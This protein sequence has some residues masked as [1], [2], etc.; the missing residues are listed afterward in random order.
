M[1]PMA[2]KKEDKVAATEAVEIVEETQNEL[3]V[4]DDT[5]VAVAGS[6]I[7]DD[8][9]FE[10]LGFDADEL[11][12]L[13][14]LES[15]NASDIRVPF[16]KFWAVTKDGFEAGDIQLPDGSVIK[17]SQ[18]EILKGLSILKPATV[19]VYF[20]SPYKP[21]NTFICRSLDGKTGATD[22]KFA[23]TACSSCEFSQYPEEGAPPCREQILLLCTLA[24]GTL[25]HLL[26]S[27]MS[28]GNWKR[29]FLSVEM[30]KNMS[31]VKKAMRGK[32]VLAALN[33]EAS[34][35][36]TK[37]DYGVKPILE[38]KVNKEKPLHDFNRI[39]ENLEAYSNYKTFETE[40][41]ESAAKFAQ[42]EQTEYTDQD[43]ATNGENAG[44][45]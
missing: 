5:Q 23:G 27:G 44:M 22:G 25:F 45:F 10:S 20:P 38:F 6:D 14:G 9:D 12:G 21:S 28:V 35:G 33:I 43:E 13:S 16:G 1:K 8:F 32:A 29:Q 17:G 2:T 30:M 41:I 26:V 19:R 11:D 42:T 15:I 7:P 31:L 4:P 18:G 40:A 36:E 37:T 24:D 3:A 34:I 39:K